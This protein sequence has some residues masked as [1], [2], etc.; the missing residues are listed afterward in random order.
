MNIGLWLLV[1][2]G[3]KALTIGSEFNFLLWCKHGKKYST[4][5]FNRP[6]FTPEYHEQEP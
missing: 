1:V 5:Y 3:L 2:I 4:W 6:K